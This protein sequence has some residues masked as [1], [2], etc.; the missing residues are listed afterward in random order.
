MK[1]LAGLGIGNLLKR[2]TS[3]IIVKWILGLFFCYILWRLYVKLRDK[4]ETDRIK[5]RYDLAGGADVNGASFNYRASVMLLWSLCYD[6]MTEDESKIIEELSK[7]PL[8]TFRDYNSEYNLYLTTQKDQNKYHFYNF[9]KGRTLQ[10]DMQH[11]LSPS[12]YRNISHMF[13]YL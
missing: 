10:E 8:T 7:C 4:L 9:Y 12:E 6:G 13:N 3:S 2:I 11:F 5:R 1:F